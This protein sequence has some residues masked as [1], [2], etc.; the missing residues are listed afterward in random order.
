[1]ARKHVLSTKMFDEEVVSSNANS[2]VIN[3]GQTDLA[4]IDLAWSAST[5]VATV[6]LEAR[7]EKNGVWRAV[8]IGG[9]PSISGSSGDHQIVLNE[10]PF[11]ELRLAVAFTSGSG[12]LDASITTKS[13]GA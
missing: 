2:K 12:T 10:M 13:K 11:L 5:L 1:M 7:T 4:A 9:T 8:D 3:V 6:T